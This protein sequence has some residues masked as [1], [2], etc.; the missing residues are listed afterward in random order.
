[1]PI[2]HDKIVNIFNEDSSKKSGAF[3]EE[4]P[5]T[6]TYNNYQHIVV[7]FRDIQESHQGLFLQ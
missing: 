4:A 6:L 1:M 5:Q 7:R 3:L 2:N